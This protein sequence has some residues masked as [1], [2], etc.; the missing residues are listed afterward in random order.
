MSTTVLDRPPAGDG[1]IRAHDTD[2]TCDRAGSLATP[3]RHRDTYRQA[4]TRAAKPTRLCAVCGSPTIYGVCGTCW[5]R[6]RI[7]THISAEA[8]PLR[9]LRP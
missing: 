1:E 4:A 3:S 8:R 6:A 9:G 5:R 7:A 2:P